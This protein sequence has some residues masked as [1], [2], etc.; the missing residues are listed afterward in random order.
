MRSSTRRYKS[1]IYDASS[2]ISLDRL[3]CSN[4]TALNIAP[5]FNQSLSLAMFN[6]PDVA[7][8]VAFVEP[9]GEDGGEGYIITTGHIKIVCGASRSLAI[10]LAGFKFV[11][12]SNP[13]SGLIQRLRV[14]VAGIELT[15]YG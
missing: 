2:L 6:Y 3:R 10:A 5:A 11:I 4:T 8:P 9:P 13:V 1:A 15:D 14:K 7:G 12:D